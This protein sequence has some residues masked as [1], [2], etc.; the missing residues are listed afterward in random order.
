MIPFPNMAS[1]AKAMAKHSAKMTRLIAESFMAVLAV[2]WR[3]PYR[4]E[5]RLDSRFQAATL[6]QDQ[7]IF[8]FSSLALAI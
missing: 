4:M 5:T 7:Y 2:F 6:C 8:P 3:K 1:H